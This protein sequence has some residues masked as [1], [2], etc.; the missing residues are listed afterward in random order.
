VGELLEWGKEY[1][2]GLV[3]LAIA[4]LNGKSIASFIRGIFERLTPSWAEKKALEEKRR[5][6]ELERL[7]HEKRQ[8]EAERIDT[9][10]ALKDVLIAQREELDRVRKEYREELDDAK[11]ERRDLQRTLYDFIGKYERLAAQV[12]EVLRDLSDLTR[13][14]LARLRGIE[15]HEREYRT[16][17]ADGQESA[18]PEPTSDSPD[19]KAH[20]V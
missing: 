12:T 5:Q 18:R 20:R 19:R 7:E 17:Q 11:R 16:T 1:G 8:R 6:A 13:S 14:V 3:L 10:L 9:I 4:I 15:Q 2:W